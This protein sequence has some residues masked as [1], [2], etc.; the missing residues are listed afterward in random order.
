MVEVSDLLVGSM[1]Q[2]GRVDSIFT[3]ASCNV[4]QELTLHTENKDTSLV[5]SQSDAIFES[6]IRHR[7]W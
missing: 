5:K 2:A 1:I 3:R 7:L 4:E 6:L